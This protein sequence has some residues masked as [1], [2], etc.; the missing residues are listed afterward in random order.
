MAPI[1]YCEIKLDLVNSIL[2]Q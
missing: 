2:N 1:E